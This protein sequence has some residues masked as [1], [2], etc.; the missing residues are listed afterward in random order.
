MK[1][2]IH[3]TQEKP[4]LISLLVV[5]AFLAS[6]AISS[7]DLESVS[8]EENSENKVSSDEED[9][10]DE[11][12]SDAKL[13]E[14]L[15]VSDANLEDFKNENLPEKEEINSAKELSENDK[16]AKNK[17]IEDQSS[18]L[19]N[20]EPAAAPALEDKNLAKAQPQVAVPAV[21]EKSAIAPELWWIGFDYHE[22]KATAYIELLT[23]GKPKYDLE[24][25]KNAQGFIDLIIRF[26]SAIMKPLLA[27]TIVAT[28]FASP[29]ETIK[30]T[31]QPDKSGVEVA[32]S[33]RDN[34]KPKL[35]AHE[36]NILLSFPLAKEYLKKNSPKTMASG[37]VVELNSINILPVVLAGSEKPKSYV[38]SHAQA[39]EY[40]NQYHESDQIPEKPLQNPES[41]PENQ[42]LKPSNTTTQGINQSAVEEDFM[43]KMAYVASL[44]RLSL[45]MVGKDDGIDPPASA[46]PDILNKEIKEE[47]EAIQQDEVT[48]IVKEQKPPE[49]GKETKSDFK[50]L[51]IEFKDAKLKDVIAA[52]A[53]ENGSNF[54]VGNGIGDNP[55]TLKLRNVPWDQA[56]QAVLETNALGLTKL[57]GNVIRVDSLVKL[58]E[59]KLK[60]R[61][62][63]KNSAMLIPTKILVMRLSYSQA[64]EMAKTVADFLASA[65]EDKRVRVQA[66]ARTNTLVVEAIPDD[67][68]KVKALV[69][70]IDLQTPQVKIATRVVEVLDDNSNTFGIN[71]ST[72]LRSDQG[73]GI[74]MGNLVFPN[75]VVS[76]FAV[77]TGVDPNAL[78][79]AGTVGIHIGSIN[80]TIELD[81][82]LRMSETQNLTRSLQNNNIIVL[83]NQK[84]ILESGR[85]DFFPLARSDGKGGQLSEL[86]KVEY[87]LRLEVTPHITSDGSVQMDIKVEN[88]SPTEFDTSKADASRNK[89]LL[90][91]NMLRKSGETVV[92]GGLYTTDKIDTMHG[93][94][95]FSKIP[96]LGVFFRSSNKSENRRELIIMVTPTVIQSQK[97]DAE[98][99]ENSEEESDSNL[100]EQSTP[101]GEDQKVNQQ[102]AEQVSNKKNE[103]LLPNEK[104]DEP[105]QASGAN[106]SNN[107]QNNQLNQTTN[108]Q[109]YMGRSANSLAYKRKVK[110]SM[111]ERKR[112]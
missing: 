90:T 86:S 56:L 1:N 79:K 47:K 57:D 10:A 9:V 34:V 102:A 40:Q 69:E 62:V 78:S 44:P 93:V 19:K 108:N 24:Q 52:L 81:L 107:S 101:F 103:N 105:N 109:A 32:I 33:L 51:N 46:D 41:L 75:S 89:R 94:P 3:S 54:I 88:A 25:R 45:L 71:W 72:P 28:E 36:G 31:I 2:L 106:Q 12:D 76:A 61:E 92:I 22:E 38:P 16:D 20:I 96:L 23:K 100:S 80:N 74:N 8:N 21:P 68:E 77:D 85:E 4:G 50:V 5:L 14:E 63:Q 82:R 6:C 11:L 87:V 99:F 104:N 29:I 55:V 13:D 59:E 26:E 27:R 84:A 60:L 73:A 98:N 91:T 18:S 35:F 110:K 112:L 42:E 43:K 58:N 70:R 83:D 111:S 64:V 53:K 95:G 15:G 7:N 37:K 66:D 17:T 39:K 97:S 67:L 30:A 65:Q 48:P 49:V